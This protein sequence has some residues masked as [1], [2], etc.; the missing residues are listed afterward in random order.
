MEAQYY[1]K[2]DGNFIKCNLCPNTC[3]I[4]ESKSGRCGVRKNVNGFLTLPFYSKISA[5]ALDPIEK[6]PLYH[7][8]PGTQIL[9]VGFV[10]CSLHCPFCQNY[11][12]SQSTTARCDDI[13]PEELVKIAS[14]QKS[15]A[16]AY[17]YSE[18]AIHYE[19]ILETSQLAKKKGLKNVLVSNGYLNPEPAEELLEVTDAAN[20]DLKSFN[21]DFYS[22]ELGGKLHSVL[23]FLDLA[24]KK[25][26]LEVTTL[27]IPG[28]ND[29]TEEIKK[30]AEY[31]AGLGKNIPL[32]LSCYY[33]TYKY[34]IPATTTKTVQHLAEVAKK[35]LNF[36]YLG[37]VGGIET[38]TY[39]TE[40]DNLLIKRSGYFIKTSGI[41]N[42]GCSRCG[43]AIP[44]Q[45]V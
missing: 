8:Y 16:I 41:R 5:I 2:K 20:I 28:K 29:S 25:T 42:G 31:I 3:V 37:N 32:H 9:S 23:N 7:F 4:A 34:T 24:A 10:G 13:S 45:G 39:C 18:P 17:T 35:Y 26:A 44:I 43:T 12:I 38:N 1:I 22:K 14:D 21:E 27:V 19:Y 11:H 6:K 33:P 40:C 30:I 15:F 36:V